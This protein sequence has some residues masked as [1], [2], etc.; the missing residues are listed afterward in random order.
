MCRCLDL[1]RIQPVS[2]QVK[3]VLQLTYLLE[4]A[5]PFWRVL[6]HRGLPASVDF[7]RVHPS[8][9]GRK[10]HV[11]FEVSDRIA[12]RAKKERVVV[13]AA[14]HKC[15]LHFR[16]DRLVVLQVLGQVRR[17]KLKLEANAPTTG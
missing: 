16:P 4:R 14:A 15:L 11:C 5:Q 7:R 9:R 6:C 13:P 10:V 8:A 12:V 3:V 17:V 2:A 1:R